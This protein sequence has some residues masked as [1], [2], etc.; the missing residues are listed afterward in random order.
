[1]SSPSGDGA[2][3]SA[4]PSKRLQ[5]NTSIDVAAMPRVLRRIAVE[6]VRQAPWRVVLTM[7]ASLGAAAASLTLPGLFGRAV[8][9]AQRLVGIAS[10][11]RDAAQATALHAAGASA[12]TLRAA[13][14]AHG[15]RHTLLLT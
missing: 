10:R 2:S 11:T 4:E 5:E 9:E 7:G 13:A 12:D 8:N 14:L 1:M 15:A 3:A 6:A